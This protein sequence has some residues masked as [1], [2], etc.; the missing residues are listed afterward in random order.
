MHPVIPVMEKRLFNYTNLKNIA[1]PGAKYR[2]IV[3]GKHS[4]VICKLG[5]IIIA[6]GERSQ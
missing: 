6:R 1:L 5:Q 4:K 3:K 2:Y